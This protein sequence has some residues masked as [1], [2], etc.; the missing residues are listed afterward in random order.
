MFGSKLSNDVKEYEK[1]VLFQ[2]PYAL[3]CKISN[4]VFL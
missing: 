2:R 3:H 1:A 4:L